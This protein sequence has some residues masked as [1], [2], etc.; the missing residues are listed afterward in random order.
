M[1]TPR[2]G[3]D[4]IRELTYIRPAVLMD[5]RTISRCPTCGRTENCVCDGCGICTGPKRAPVG[6]SDAA[7][8]RIME[9]L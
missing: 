1:N 4:P 8:Q 7:L 6:L 2:V 3:Y 5:D 9:E